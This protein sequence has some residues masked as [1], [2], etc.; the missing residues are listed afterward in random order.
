MMVPGDLTF[1]YL[2]RWRVDDV[3]VQVI[4][5]SRAAVAAR[6]SPRRSVGGIRARGARAVIRGR[7]RRR[8]RAGVGLPAV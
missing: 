6:G 3:V 7:G 1:S 4:R 2:D 8:V 5:L